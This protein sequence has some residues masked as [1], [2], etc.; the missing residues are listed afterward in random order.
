MQ[1][2]TLLLPKS[3]DPDKLCLVE[4]YR[5]ITLCNVDYKIFA[6]ILATRLQGV[7]TE[8]VGGHQTC[9]IRG[10][11]IHTNIHV[12]R[13]VLDCCTS[14]GRRVA[15]L[16]IDFAKAFD[17]VN[18]TVLFDILT[19]VRCGSVILEGIEMAY[20]NCSTRLVINS[21]LTDPI[22]IQSSVRQGCPLSPLL[23]ALYLEP[24]CLSIIRNQDIRGF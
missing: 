23:F 15:V 10:R 22:A 21:A 24:F 19:H 16:Q 14:E 17:R 5:P 12:A 4:S 11:T 8:L 13:S 20:K 9:G 2:H 3:E 7:I 18:H 1:A 6:K